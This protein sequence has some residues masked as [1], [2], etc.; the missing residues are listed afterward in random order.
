MYYNVIRKWVRELKI[1]VVEDNKDISKILEKYLI[2]EEYN[3]DLAFD[4][5]EA[6][7]KFHNNHY[8]LIVLDL[9]LPVCSGEEVLAEIRK[10]S[11][12]P[13]IIL[14]AKTGQESKLH[15]LVAGA[16]DYVT[17]PFSAKEVVA[18]VN[19]LIRRVKEYSE[20]NSAHIY[21]DG[22]L[23]VNFEK[24]EVTYNGE[25]VTF[26]ANEFK[27]LSTL[28]KNKGI[29]L[30]REQ[31]IEKVFNNDFDGYD[32]NIDTYIKNIRSKLDKKYVVTVYS[33]GYKFPEEGDL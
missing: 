24:M 5:G 8:D 4:G 2:N 28:M 20:F 1:L 15:G 14:S 29:A 32:R 31:I 11:A 9:M 27:V 26:T 12:V 25:N 7:D 30:S 33:I 22:V 19:A 21:D 23:K 6:L 16:D 3:V 13:V 17:K 10:T 18:R